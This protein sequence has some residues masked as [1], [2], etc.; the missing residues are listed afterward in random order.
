MPDEIPPPQGPAPAPPPPASI[1]A[2][3][4][5]GSAPP[6][7]L[8]GTAPA[9]VATR[10]GRGLLRRRNII[11]AAVVL[12]LVIGAISEQFAGHNGNFTIVSSSS[13]DGTFHGGDCVSLTSTKVILAECSGAHDAQI[14]DVIH[15]SDSCPVGTEEYSVKDGTGNLCLDKS[16]SSR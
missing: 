8:P 12:L 9:A 14:I 4:P 6:A 3:A 5:P 11:I 15:G 16:N 1:P 10:P 2:A 7:P 13:T